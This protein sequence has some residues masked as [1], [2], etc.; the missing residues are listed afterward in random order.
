MI[1]MQINMSHEFIS[2]TH[3]PRVKYDSS[4]ITGCRFTELRNT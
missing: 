3:S 1:P 2:P 4:K